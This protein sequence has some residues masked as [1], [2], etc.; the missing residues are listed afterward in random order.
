MRTLDATDARIVLALDA[1][2]QATTVALARGLGL[3]RN[4]VQARLTALEARGV[5]SAAS[6][7]V[8]PAALGHTITAFVTMTI[9]QGDVEQ[10]TADLA[11]VPEIIE[12][13][14]TTGDGDLLAKVVARDP[15]DLHR[16]TRRMLQAGAVVRTST[17]M[18]VLEL[19]A[20]RMAP[21]LREVAGA[22]PSAT[23]RDP[24]P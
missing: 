22:G 9:S 7:R 8:R 21:L 23:A 1:D 12:L 20:P 10:I 19:I 13:Y 18:A 24:R 17:A 14:A 3:A 5:L 11:G 4:T 2:P 6:T 16:I 15:A